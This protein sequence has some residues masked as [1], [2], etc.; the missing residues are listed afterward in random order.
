MRFLKLLLSSLFIYF[1][2]LCAEAQI[3]YDWQVGI[4]NHFQLGKR[5]TK[6]IDPVGATQHLPR[7]NFSGTEGVGLQIGFTRYQDS[8]RLLLH[9]GLQHIFGNLV[10]MGS[11]RDTGLFKEELLKTRLTHLKLGAGFKIKQFTLMAGPLLPMFSKTESRFFLEDSAN[12]YYAVYDLKFKPSIGLWMA[13]DYNIKV[14]ENAN[15]FIG[16]GAQILNRTIDSKEIVDFKT[17]KGNQNIDFFAPNQYQKETVFID[18]L[19]S[20]IN[21]DVSNPSGVNYNQAREALSQS[22]SYSSWYIKFGLRWN[23]R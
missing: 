22:Y 20:N 19:S 7:L 2:F 5:E 12:K 21:N 1:G 14:Q 3:H 16:L 4:E 9:T 15:V 11:L 10:S 23:I 8:S 18:E 17:Y 6:N 13:L